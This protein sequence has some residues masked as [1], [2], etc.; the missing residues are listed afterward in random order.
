MV[1]HDLPVDGAVEFLGAADVDLDV[2]GAAQILTASDDPAC[3]FE[4]EEGFRGAGV[5]PLGEG[6]AAGVF[7]VVA[8]CALRSLT[9][10]GRKRSPVALTMQDQLSWAT[11]DFGTSMVG[12]GHRAA[13]ACCI[14]SPHE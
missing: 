6:G 4:V 3:A 12:V 1:N 13:S 10:L 7:V 14:T 9:P 5:L 11:T 8:M 2:L